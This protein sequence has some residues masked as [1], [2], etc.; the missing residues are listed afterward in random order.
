[1][2]GLFFSFRPARHFYAIFTPKCA[3]LPCPL[4]A[5]AYAGVVRA[6]LVSMARPM[7]RPELQ[8]PR[9]WQPYLLALGA[10]ALTALV[11]TPLRDRLDLANTVMLFLLAVALVAARLGRGPAI[12]AAFCSVALFDFFFV[13]PRL[14]FTVSDVQ[15][16]VTFAVMLAVALLISHLTTGL[17]DQARAA[18]ARERQT[19]SLYELAKALA[20]AVTQEQ[21]SAASG[22]F[23]REHLHAAT[24]L[25]LADAEETLH[26][27]GGTLSVAGEYHARSVY[28]SGAPAT[29][30]DIAGGEGHTL[31]LPLEGSTRRRGVLAVSVGPGEAE[32]LAQQRPLLQAGASLI[33][34]A[35]E[36]LHFVE[37]AQTSQLQ[38]ASERLRSSILSALS[39]DVRTPLTV[40][41]GLADSLALSP[42]TLAPAARDTVLA[43]RD[44]SLRLNNMVANLLDMAR[45]QAGQIRLRKE[46]QP[47]EEVVGASIKLLGAGL[48][49][50]RVKV[51]L[52]PELP[53]VEFDAV[54]MERVFCNLLENA[55]KYSPAA[56]DIEL[57]AQASETT[58]EVSACNAGPG[59]PPQQM[60]R[61]FEL[62]ARGET[63]S[64]VP[65]FGVGLAICRA[66][67]DAHGG[68]LR[69]FNPET[70]GACVSF[71]LP[72]GTPPPI[73]TEPA[74]GELP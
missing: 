6:Y 18:T 34:I 66:I 51:H 8:K 45:L 65:G 46:W 23:V 33:A 29:V 35:V 36:R 43:I 68:T 53:L 72:R 25:V 12:A 9:R 32:A 67:I 30:D 41:Y 40:I 20:G 4:R 47:L 70:G 58:I 22:A 50:H 60:E 16:L 1:M 5:L 21:V 48:E 44:Q 69:A 38:A 14:S 57:R 7:S 74:T 27:F 28:A 42:A 61:M 63:E 49:G 56:T 73:E 62:F 54:L 64:S 15:Y 10:C 55:A 24:T 26:P 59:F 31:L 2:V 39:H 19:R 13:P 3:K 52:P 37:V 17:A 71:T 11:A